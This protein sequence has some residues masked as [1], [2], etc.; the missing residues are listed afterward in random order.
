MTVTV[1]LPKKLVE[2]LRT[3]AERT[4]QDLDGT[5][6]GLLEEQLQ[7][8]AGLSPPPQPAPTESELLQQFQQGLSEATWERYHEL[9]GKRE[10]EQLSPAEQR[11]L[12]ALADVIEGWNVRRLE[13]A[14]QLA[15]RR[16]V[17]WQ[18]IVEELG[19]AAPA[20]P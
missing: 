20:R 10:A 7:C 13:L 1:Q 19:L 17:S 6:A 18:Q 15:D 3:L 8:Q 2:A 16:G 11:E 4:G 14:Q 9:Q 12:I 5:I